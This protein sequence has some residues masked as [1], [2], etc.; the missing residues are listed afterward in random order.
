MFLEAVIAATFTSLALAFVYQTR[1]KG[2]TY[3]YEELAGFGTVPS[4]DRDEFGDTLNF[5]SNLAIDR[6]KWE[7]LAN[8]S[9]TGLLWGLPD[10]GWDIHGTLNFQPRVHRF[11]VL[12]T[13]G[14]NATVEKPSDKNLFWLK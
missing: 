12:H 4:S 3:T 10:L 9:F 1:C 7:K 5:S 6:S 2:R 13:P 14:P 11:D 8:V